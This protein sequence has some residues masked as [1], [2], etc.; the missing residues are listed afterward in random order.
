MYFIGKDCHS[1]WLLIGHFFILKALVRVSLWNILFLIMLRCRWLW[2]YPWPWV[3][4]WLP[5]TLPVLDVPLFVHVTRVWALGLD[6]RILWRL[7][8]SWDCKWSLWICRRK[9]ALAGLHVIRISGWNRWKWGASIF[10]TLA[11]DLGLF[12]M[13]VLLW[14]LLMIFWACALWRCCLGIYTSSRLSSSSSKYEFS[15]P[16]WFYSDQITIWSDTHYL[17]TSKLMWQYFSKNHTNLLQYYP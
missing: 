1:L 2:F 16:Q 7:S 6:L 9:L 15:N 8:G 13:L 10:N 3:A 11:V 14:E 17:M 4:P 5:Q 12:G